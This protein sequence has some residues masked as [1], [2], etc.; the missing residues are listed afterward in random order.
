MDLLY[1]NVYIT[2]ETFPTEVRKY[3]AIASGYF[4]KLPGFNDFIKFNSGF[5]EILF[6]DKWIQDG[7]S[8]ARLK[9]RASWKEKYGS[10]PPTSFYI[11]FHSSG[12]AAAGIIYSSYD[13]SGREFPLVVFSVIPLKYFTSLHLIPA[14]LK[15]TISSLDHCIRKEENLN[16][17]NLALKNFDPEYV[18]EDT[19]SRS[20]QE[21]LSSTSMNSFTVETGVSASYVNS[22]NPPSPESTGIRISFKSDES[23]ITFNTAV[24]LKILNQRLKLSTGHTSIFWNKSS[25]AD[26][27]LMIFP[28]K[29]GTVSFI[30]LISPNPEDRRIINIPPGDE[31]TLSESDASTESILSF[32]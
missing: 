3:K 10:L 1:G 18:D 28:L 8:D 15:E 31:C 14:M 26:F 16:D 17:L 21:F 27:R 24:F 9:L 19:L 20:F 22:I 7:L 25:D 5:P 32:L 30:D 23:K 6:I 12:R 13:K 11:P 29:P 4:G 2:S